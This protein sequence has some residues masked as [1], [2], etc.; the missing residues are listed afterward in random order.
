MQTPLSFYAEM[1]RGGGGGDGEAGGG[2]DVGGGKN[3]RWAAMS[4]NAS[5]EYAL[6]N[7]LPTDTRVCCVTDTHNMTETQTH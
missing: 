5:T 7:C 1:K 3:P 6:E 4:S 2:R